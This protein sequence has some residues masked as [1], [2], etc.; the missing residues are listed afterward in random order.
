MT[1][2]PRARSRKAAIYVEDQRLDEA[3]DRLL[4]FDPEH[5]N[6]RDYVLSIAGA[7]LGAPCRRN[8]KTGCT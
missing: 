3:V 5:H 6:P 2:K 1:G 8:A 7:M 4:R